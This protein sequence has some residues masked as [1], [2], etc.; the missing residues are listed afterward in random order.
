LYLHPAKHIQ[1][2]SH[3][4]NSCAK[5][6]TIRGE[7]QKISKLSVRNR[8]NDDG[9][10]DLP[11]AM[12]PIHWQRFTAVELFQAPH[13]FGPSEEMLQGRITPNVRKQEKIEW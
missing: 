3:E 5:R 9:R 8:T 11:A 4:K 2:G 6:G 1:R 13:E 7:T 12:N 10:K